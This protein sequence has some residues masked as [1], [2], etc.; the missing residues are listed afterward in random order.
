VQ[1]GYLTTAYPKASHTFI[2]TEIRALESFGHAVARFAI[3]PAPDTLV[4]PLDLEEQARTTHCLAQPIPVLLGALLVTALTQPGRLAH[5]LATSLALSAR[6]ERGLVRHLAYLVEACW[7]VRV[8]RER[9]VEHVHVHFGTNAAAV[10]L[11]A[12]E[13]GGPSYSLTVHGP[14]EFDA[15][16]GLSLDR[17]IRAARFVA[18]I[19]SHCSAQLRRWADLADWSKIHVVHCGVDD[20]F[21]A[22][23]EPVDGAS[24]SLVCVGRLTPQK[25]QLLLLDAVAA[26]RAEGVELELTLAGDGELR[27]ALEQRIRELGLEKAVAITGWVSS[28]EIRALL[29][30]A[31]A[32]VLPSFAEGLPVVIMEALAMARPVVASWVA[33]IPELVRPGES[34]WLVPPGDTAALIEALREVLC[35]PAHELDR[36]GRSGRERVRARHSALAE[37]RKLERL[38]LAGRSEAR[39]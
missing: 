12:S 6:S 23:D 20:G 3:R 8:L 10:A 13:L 31:R 28:G 17:K 39:A 25:G 5:A 33:G 38:L 4:D 34:G 37:A 16:I 36:R 27:P 14:G 24:R 29:R 19:T 26:L 7:L 30:S 35:A 9:G 1:I 11:L 15:P 32:L 18:A 21:F 2:R 22:S